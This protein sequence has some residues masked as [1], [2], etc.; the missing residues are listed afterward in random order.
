MLAAADCEET[1]GDGFDHADCADEHE[2]A[3]S[4]GMGAEAQTLDVGPALETCSRRAHFDGQ[5]KLEKRNE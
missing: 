5:S 1:P 4:S 3:A 2:G